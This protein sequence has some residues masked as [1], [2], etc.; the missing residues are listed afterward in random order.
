MQKWDFFVKFKNKRP[1]SHCAQKP[2]IIMQNIFSPPSP[3]PA[4]RWKTKNA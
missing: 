1:F 2:I 3:D 4:M